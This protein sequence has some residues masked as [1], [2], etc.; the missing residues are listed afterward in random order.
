MEGNRKRNEE[1]F[2]ALLYYKPVSPTAHKA[3][4]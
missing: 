4:G 2:S 3:F 1:F